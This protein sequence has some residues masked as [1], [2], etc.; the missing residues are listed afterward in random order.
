[1]L[2]LP[3]GTSAFLVCLLSRSRERIEERAISLEEG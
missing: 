1:M 3:I 2:L